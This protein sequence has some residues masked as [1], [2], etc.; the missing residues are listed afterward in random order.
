MGG[1]VETEVTDKTTHVVSPNEERTMNIL[2]GVIRACVIVN[3]G[4]I[5]DSLAKNKWL[6][7]T[8][9]QHDICDSNKVRLKKMIDT[10]DDANQLPS[11]Q[12]YER[13]VLGTKNY[14][15]LSFANRGSFYLN[16]ETID[17]A[18]KV[19]YLKEVITLCGGKITE[20]KTEARYIVSD[21]PI[22]GKASKQI[23]VNS[24]YIFDS[25][26]KGALLDVTRSCIPK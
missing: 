21:K 9:Y 14:K 2:R 11:L 10:F 6:E 18:K 23:D 3:V 25:S 13:S 15:N 16:K 26:M 20:K 4:W 12:V 5:H 22:H 8:T 19:D 1:K 7:T 24:N 17:N